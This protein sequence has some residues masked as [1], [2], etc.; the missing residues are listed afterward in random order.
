MTIKESQSRRGLSLRVWL[1]CIVLLGATGSASAQQTEQVRDNDGVTLNLKDADLQAVIAMVAERT[2]R[3]FIVDP[4]VKGRVTVISQQ[5]VSDDELYQVFLS[6]L[7]IHGFAAVPGSGAIKIV[8]EVLAKQDEVPT[9]GPRAPGRGDEFVTRVIQ[10]EHVDAAQLVPIL[11]PLIPQR[12]HLAAYP[13]SNMLILSD[14]AANLQ[15]L[16]EIIERMDRSSTEEVE[17]VRVEHASA[18]EI[19]RILTAMEAGQEGQRPGA[20]LQISAD[21]R[22]NSILLGGDGSQRLRMRALISHLDQRVEGA[23]N[24]HVIYLRYASAEALLPVIS[25]IAGSITEGMRGGQG[26]GAQG[27]QGGGAQQAPLNIQAD[28]ATNAI[29]VHA[30]PDVVRSLRTVIQQL[31]VRRAQVHVEAIIAEVSATKSRELGVRWGFGSSDGPVGILELPE[32]GPPLSNALTSALGPAALVGSGLNL[33]AGSFT[34]SFRFGALLRTLA[35]DAGTNI[36][37]TPTLVTM[38]NEEAEIVVGQNVP[39]VT[40]RYTATGDTTTPTSPFQ[41]IQREDVGIKLKVRPQINEGNAIRMLI[42]QEVSSLEALS[43]TLGPTTNRRAINTTVMVDDGDILVLGGLVEDDLQELQQKVPGLGDLPVLG[44]LFRYQSTRKVKRN[45]MVFLRP[46]ILR[47]AALSHAMT[48]AKYNFIRGEQ[49]AV[50]ERGVRM[51]PDTAAPKLPELDTLL[52]LPAPYEEAK[53]RREAEERGNEAAPE[54]SNDRDSIAT[55]PRQSFTAPPQ[56]PGVERR[57]SREW[58]AIFD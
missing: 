5:P 4:R 43:E 11:R 6:L 45:L 30:A 48:G 56:A 20:R 57:A 29:V 34:G 10:V 9:V 7:K 1:L 2:G 49:A 23:G 50:R 14:S 35:D 55:P 26:G 47:D 27:G 21:A 24:T 28:A 38:D 17:V 39:F 16:A 37:S 54:R 32:A 18:G 36:L 41:T 12:G 42:E 33:A 31:D 53:R 40:G 51:M 44:G 15:R 52:E 46:V 25:G 8:P 58:D 13:P 19:V 22:T 3:N